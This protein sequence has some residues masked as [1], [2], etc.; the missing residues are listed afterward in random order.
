MIIEL[1]VGNRSVP[2]MRRDFK[3]YFAD[4]HLVSVIGIKMFGNDRKLGYMNKVLDID[5]II[6][7]HW[8]SSLSNAKSRRGAMVKRGWR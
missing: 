7:S 1:E 8:F 5:Y 3:M 2:D 6:H 4:P